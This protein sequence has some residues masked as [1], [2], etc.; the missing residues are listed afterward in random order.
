MH[1]DEKKKGC[2]LEG[3][4]WS[5]ENRTISSNIPQM[6]PPCA[7][8]IR[9]AEGCILDDMSNRHKYHI[10]GNLQ[11][12]LRSANRNTCRK[13]PGPFNNKIQMFDQI[14]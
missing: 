12:A 14:L 5:I 2:V 13:I 8:I 11:D 9:K 4:E 10:D 3:E 1:W 7:Y 6:Q